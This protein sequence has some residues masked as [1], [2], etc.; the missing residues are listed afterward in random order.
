[1]L[2]LQPTLARS[3]TFRRTRPNPV[4]G[5][6]ELARFLALVHVVMAFA[7]FGIGNAAFGTSWNAPAFLHLG[8]GATLLLCAVTLWRR[9][10]GARWAVLLNLTVGVA[11][12]LTFTLNRLDGASGT[13]WWLLSIAVAFVLLEGFTLQYTTPF[14]RVRRRRQ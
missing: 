5:V 14:T 11:V 2:A 10:Q 12:V 1:M 13:T 4:S 8:F 6:K 9:G 7:A 3:A